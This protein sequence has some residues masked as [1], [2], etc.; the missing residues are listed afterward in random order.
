MGNHHTGGGEGRVD[1]D[2]V[3]RETT[4]STTP[5]RVQ[6]STAT[7]T[8]LLADASNDSTGPVSP[9]R[10]FRNHLTEHSLLSQPT[11]GVSD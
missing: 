5:Q 1:H 4:Q 3:E 11:I 9:L 8:G 10:R 7:A 2:Q 6:D